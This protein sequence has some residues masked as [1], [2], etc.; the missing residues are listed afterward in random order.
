VILEG[1]C[2]SNLESIGSA[3]AETRTKAQKDKG[4]KCLSLITAEVFIFTFSILRVW[5]V[6]N[7][8]NPDG[9]YGNNHVESGSNLAGFQKC[10]V[11]VYVILAILETINVFP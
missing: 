11:L 5:A 6:R 8:R 9:S 4:A 2:T 1:R 10:S 7:V 3:Q